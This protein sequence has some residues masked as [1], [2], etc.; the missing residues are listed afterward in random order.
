M[1]IGMMYA[2]DGEIESLL[3][4]ENAHF[5][6]KVAGASFY[7]IREDVVACAGGVGKVNAAMSTQ[8]LLSRY[9]PDVVLNVGVAGCFENVPIGTLVLATGF[10]QHDA[11]TS[12]LG[13]PVGLVS[14]VNMVSFPTSWQEKSRLAMDK[15][16]LPYRTGLVATGDWFATDTPRSHWIYDTF[17]PLLCEMEG[18]AVAQVCHRNGVPFIALKSVSDCVLEHHDFYFNFPQ[19]MKDLNRVALA[20]VDGLEAE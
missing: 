10:V 14:T 6:E 17:H 12:A 13:D 3:K 16:G 4:N 5:L 11:D 1:K 8:L 2:M 9:A 20:L 19:A 15:L 18:G 7:Q